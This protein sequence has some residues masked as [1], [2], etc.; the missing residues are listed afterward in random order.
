MI[1]AR[2]FTKGRVFLW[3]KTMFQKIWL[4]ATVTSIMVSCSPCCTEPVPAFAH[5]GADE[6]S[7]VLNAEQ[8]KRVNTLLPQGS[9]KGKHVRFDLDDKGP[10]FAPPSPQSWDFRSDDSPVKDQGSLGFCTAFSTV[11]VQEHV[12]KA[13]HAGTVVSLSEDH[14]WSMY[15]QYDSGAATQAAAANFISFEAQWPYNPNVFVNRVIKPQGHVHVA[16][17]TT[18]DQGVSQI[19]QMLKTG[20]PV[21]FSLDVSAAFMKTGSDGFVSAK[22]SRIVGGHAIEAAGVVENDLLGSYGG[23]YFILKN[24]WST[25]AGDKGYYYLPYNYCAQF[26]CYEAY[27]PVVTTLQVQ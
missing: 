21:V 13:S 20:V 6:A 22:R 16:Q 17:W 1:L 12:Y 5:P 14:L 4:S 24:S 3:E 19:V 8:T 15:Q 23:G 2:N 27:A 25:A 18:L 10:R 7:E 26:T 9:L 11:A